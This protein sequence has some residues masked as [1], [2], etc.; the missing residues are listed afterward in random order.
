MVST[1]AFREI[2]RIVGVGGAADLLG[3][4]ANRIRQFIDEGMLRAQRIGTNYAIFES[5]VI[6]FADRVRL[7]GRPPIYE[8]NVLPGE[9]VAHLTKRSTAIAFCGQQ[10]SSAVVHEMGPGHDLTGLQWCAGCRNA[11]PR[12][13]VRYYGSRGIG[14]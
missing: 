1:M 7:P 9:R 10:I 2:D 6:E 14:S 12:H 13:L 3:L 4:S 8:V 5:D 11:A